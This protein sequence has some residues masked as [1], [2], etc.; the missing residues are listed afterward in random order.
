MSRKARESSQA[1]KARSKR[2]AS[3]KKSAPAT[4]VPK[5]TALVPKELP[6]VPESTIPDF[7]VRVAKGVVEAQAR[8]DNLSRQYNEE[9]AKDLV[10]R[11]IDPGI[12]QPLQ[13]RI[14]AVNATL[15]VALKS[16]T[17]EA[18]NLVFVRTTDSTT[19]ELLQKVEFSIEAQLASPDERLRLRTAE[20][21]FRPVTGAEFAEIEEALARNEADNYKPGDTR[22]LRQHLAAGKQIG[23]SLEGTLI[24]QDA[25]TP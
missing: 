24:L 7:F 15:N 14:P 20:P 19:D 8:L 1:A 16:I 11:G 21:G 2:K 4:P 25:T 23:R 10:A 12:L 3:A 17:E 22:A 18:V 13:F 5:A 9:V 6:Q